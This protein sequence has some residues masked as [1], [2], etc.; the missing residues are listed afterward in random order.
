M[1]QREPTLDDLLNEPIIM[2]IMARDGVRGAD[3][4]HLLQQARD[5]RE[6]RLIARA[7]EASRAQARHAGCYRF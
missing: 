3:I 6:Q 5:R 2:S 1:N 4:R 7:A